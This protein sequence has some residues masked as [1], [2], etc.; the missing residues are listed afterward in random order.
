MHLPQSAS[1]CPRLVVDE[2]H[3]SLRGLHYQTIRKSKLRRDSCDRFRWSTYKQTKLITAHIPNRILLLHAS[4]EASVSCKFKKCHF[5]KFS[6]QVEKTITLHKQTITCSNRSSPFSWFSRH[7]ACC[8]I[9]PQPS[10]Q[11]HG[12]QLL[13]LYHP[14][15][16]TWSYV[17][18]LNCRQGSKTARVTCRHLSNISFVVR[19]KASV[20]TD[21]RRST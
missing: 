2:L 16:E 18:F 15:S 20:A 10:W 7:S 14:G 17:V 11:F 9:H 4:A 1:T 19:K 6:W 8:R 12:S 3:K 21:L 13:L 5:L